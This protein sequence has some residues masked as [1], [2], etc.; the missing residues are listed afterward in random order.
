MALAF[1]AFYFSSH[2]QLS[3]VELPV[4]KIKAPAFRDSSIDKWNRSFPAYASLNN[5]EKEVLYWVNLARNRPAFFLDSVVRPILRLFPEVRSLEK[6]MSS[7]G[8]LPLFEP[9]RTLIQLA[10]EHAYDLASKKAPLSHNSTNGT[11]FA[12]RTERAGVKTCAGEN[13]GLGSQGILLSVVLLYLDKGLNPPGHRQSLLS[14]QYTQIGVGVKEYGADQ[15]LLV[16]EFTC[17][18]P[19]R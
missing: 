5:Y 15:L 11:S 7:A 1:L 14:R 3:E 9:H 12:T 2:A 19:F 8:S 10:R 17:P 4:K 16:Q 13:L 18:L 6:D